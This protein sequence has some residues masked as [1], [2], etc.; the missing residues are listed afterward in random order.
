M[1]VFLI[2][3][4]L[5]AAAGNAYGLDLGSHRDITKTSAHVGRNP[6]TPDGREGGEDMATAVPITSLPFEDSGNTSDNVDDYYAECPWGGSLAPDVVYSFIPP[7]DMALAVDLCGSGY[8]TQ[9]YI[10][11]ADQNLIACNDDFY[12]DDVC[13]NYVSLIQ[14]AYLTGGQTYYIVI[15]GYMSDSGDY[16]MQIVAVDPSIPC[17]LECAGVPEGEPPLADDYVDAFNSGC[18]SPD[19]PPL[20]QELAAN[21]A[22]E[23][24]FCGKSG[25]YAI[26]GWNY[27]RDTDWFLAIIGPTGTVEWTLDAEQE[28]Y[29]MLLAPNDCAEVA[30]VET[31][32]IRPCV[33]QTMII[34]GEPGSV[35]WLWVAPTEFGSPEGF[36]GHEYDYISTFTGLA[37][38]VVDTERRSL[39]GIKS[40]FR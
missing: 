40:L 2:L 27:Y 4:L 32:L 5:L 16:V 37:A 8:D 29:C 26:D 28:T 30:P 9:V 1:R 13:G 23:L 24:T 6:G 3:V 18:G 34:N 12:Y 21:A 11:D 15:D 25:W 22:G 31:M 33:P 38:G 17:E 7:Q 39:G 35:I 19:N 10:L 20:L 36:E 14:A